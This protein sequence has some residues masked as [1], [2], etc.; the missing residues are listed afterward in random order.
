MYTFSLQSATI[1]LRYVNS[2]KFSISFA[3]KI[4]MSFS[5]HD[6]GSKLIKSTYPSNFLGNSSCKKG[7]ADFGSNFSASAKPS[8][9]NS[10]VEV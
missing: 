8:G 7:F 5:Q 4:I 10:P 9:V 2:S 3:K 1:K 6:L